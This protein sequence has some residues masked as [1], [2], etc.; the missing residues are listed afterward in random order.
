MATKNGMWFKKTTSQHIQEALWWEE[1]CVRRQGG[2]DFD[3][4]NIPTDVRWIPKGTLLK[5]VNETGKVKVAKTAEVTAKAEALGTTIKVKDT[6]LIM[7]GDKYNGST[8][9]AISISDGIATLTVDTIA[10]TLEVGDVVSDYDKEKEK[11]LG[12]Q[13]ETNDLRDN[14]YPQ[15]TPTLV[16]MEI[17][18]DTLPMPI[19][20]E[21]IAELNKAGVG[22]HLFRE[23]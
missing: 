7:V 22:I 9:T 12:L 11:V 16:A 5:L 8:V 6:G 18:K 2:Y 19:S 23:Q 15:A 10:E 20:D 1:K 21:L 17:E 3:K 4:S 13:Y 14:D